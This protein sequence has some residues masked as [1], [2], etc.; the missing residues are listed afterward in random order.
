MSQHEKG[1][2]FTTAMSLKQKVY[3]YIKNNPTTIL[4]PSFGQGDLVKYTISQFEKEQKTV[5]FDGFEIDEKI[6]MLDGLQD[7]DCLTHEYC[8]FLGKKITTKYDTIIGNPPYV[9]MK[10]GNLY[11]DFIDK[12]YKLLNDNGELVFVIPSDF[13]KLTMSKKV[14]NEM[15][16]H[17]TFTHIYHPNDEKLFKNASIDVIVFRYVKDKDLEKKLIY[18]SIIKSKLKK[19]S[20]YVTNSDGLITFTEQDHT[21]MAKI[22]DF[23]DV[24]VGIVSGRDVVYKNAELGNISVLCKK[25]TVSKFIYT[26]KYPSNNKAID[27]YLLKN[28]PELLKRKIKKFNQDNWFMWGAPRNIKVMEDHKGSDCI[29]INNITRKTIIAFKGK[30]QYFGGS[31]IMLKPKE[32]TDA[33]TIDKTVAHLNSTEFKKIFTYSGRFKIGHRQLSK[34]FIDI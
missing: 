14:L 9:K 32:N 28:K 5:E 16:K 6:P 25:D 11:I 27:K 23:F 22:E 26:K 12:C 7:S 33:E 20:L 15:L 19:E 4:E 31:L 1:Q 2:Y 18:E 10:T 30:V 29:Y 17:G 21:G 24:Y 13:F 34:S 3:E 8:D